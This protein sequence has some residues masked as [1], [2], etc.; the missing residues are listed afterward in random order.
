VTQPN[1]TPDP[2]AAALEAAINLLGAPAVTVAEAAAKLRWPC[3]SP[4][5]IH[6]RIVAGTLPL[7]PRKI[8]H[9]WYITANA[10][11][12]QLLG[13]DP[14]TSDVFSRLDVQNEAAAQRRRGPG[15]PRKAAPA[16]VEGGAA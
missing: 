4:A 7:P 8:G 2:L 15:R 6:N 10:V 11:A 12:R 13:E 16:G 14:Y 9:R 5:A 3:Q 1:R